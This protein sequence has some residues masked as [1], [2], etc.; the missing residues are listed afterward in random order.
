MKLAFSKMHGAGNDLVVVNCLDGDPV[1]D[2]EAFARFALD[3]RL[4]VGGDQLLLVKPSS[5]ADF[6]MG[7][8]NS[9]GSTAEMCANGIRAFYKYLRD[10][11]LT[12]KDEVRVETLGGV[13]PP[14]H[15]GRPEAP[16]H[17]AR[18]EN[19]SPAGLPANEN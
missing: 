11:G 5:E 7:I 19:S 2:W 17:Y 1:K 3:R 13:V 16:R 4:G 9:D 6:F 18:A 14:A 8:R 15:A 10:K 12:Q